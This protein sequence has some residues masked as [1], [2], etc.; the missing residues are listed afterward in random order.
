MKGVFP[1]AKMQKNL[2][3]EVDMCDNLKI[4]QNSEV[5]AEKFY[6]P[7]NLNVEFL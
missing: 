6:R 3:G 2:A 5:S 4:N 1:V 7:V